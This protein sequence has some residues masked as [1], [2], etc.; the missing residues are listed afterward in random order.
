[1][2]VR[3]PERTSFIA[4]RLR[5]ARQTTDRSSE[6][7]KRFEHLGVGEVRVSAARV[8]QDEHPCAVDGRLLEARLDV[9]CVGVPEDSPERAI[10]RH[11]DER[12]DRGTVPRDFLLEDPPALDVLG[13]LEHVDAWARP[14]NKIRHPDAPLRQPDIVHMRHGL[15]NDAGLEQQSPEAIRRSGEM[16]S[17]QRGHDAGVDADEQHADTWLDAIRQSKMRVFRLELRH[18]LR[19]ANVRR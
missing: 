12:D 15:G 4:A 6:R 2:P 11:A 18:A 9:R 8:R 16:M 1:V 5:A 3:A 7:S 10:H 14:R 17:G 13:G 19:H